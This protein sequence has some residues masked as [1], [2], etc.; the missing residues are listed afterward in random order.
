MVDVENLSA[1]EHSIY[2]S[3]EGIFALSYR[4]ENENRIGFSDENIELLSKKVGT[5]FGFVDFKCRWA[6]GQMATLDVNKSVYNVSKNHFI[7]ADRSKFNKVL[8]YIFVAN[9]FWSSS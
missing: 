2:P 6:N 9:S 8:N 1:G 5:R 7:F 4:W 3:S